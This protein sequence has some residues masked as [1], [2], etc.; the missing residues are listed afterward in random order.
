V[1]NYTK[2]RA[3]DA[4][5]ARRRVIETHTWLCVDDFI[6]ILLCTT[7]EWNEVSAERH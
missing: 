6:A 4:S 7:A 2:L 1:D 5:V 3:L